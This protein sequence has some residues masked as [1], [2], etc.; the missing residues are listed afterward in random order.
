MGKVKSGRTLARETRMRKATAR[1]AVLHSLGVCRVS[2]AVMCNVV[3]LEPRN[4]F[5]DVK[6]N[7]TKIVWAHA[8]NSK[9]ELETALSS[10]RSIVP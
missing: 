5:P 1:R 10:G 3:S 4:F 7:L 6:G 8:V 2:E 9:A